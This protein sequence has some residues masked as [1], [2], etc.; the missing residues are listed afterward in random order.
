MTLTSPFAMLRAVRIAA[1]FAEILRLTMK[2]PADLAPSA[3][4][5]WG[6]LFAR[7][8]SEHLLGAIGRAVIDDDFDP[9]EKIAPVENF[10]TR[11]RFSHQMLL[12]VDRDQHRQR[13][14][15]LSHL[16]NAR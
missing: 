14:E 13:N 5:R 15:I 16:F 7:K 8:I 3:I 12:V 11:Q 6:S 9:G 1:P 2:G 4:G 10:E